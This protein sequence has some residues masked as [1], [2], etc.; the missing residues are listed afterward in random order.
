MCGGKRLLQLTE[1]YSS[2]N[3]KKGDTKGV[4]LER[5][6]FSLNQRS[7]IHYLQ[8]LGLNTKHGDHQRGFNGLN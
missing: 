4:R 5:Q 7:N 3:K 8:H 6:K 1:F 2:E